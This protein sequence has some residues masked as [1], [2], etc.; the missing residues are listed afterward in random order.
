ME[1]MH[2]PLHPR[3]LIGITV[4]AVLLLAAFG[5]QMLKP[6]T[7]IP[8]PGA[9]GRPPHNPSYMQPGAPP[10]YGHPAR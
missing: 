4:M 1:T 9:G 5:Y 3:V 10:P 7:Y 8:S 2:K 6:P